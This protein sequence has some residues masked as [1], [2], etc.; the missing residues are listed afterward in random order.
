M[1]FLDLYESDNQQQNADANNGA[2]NNV[3][4]KKEEPKGDVITI[5]T[6]LGDLEKFHDDRNAR[7][8]FLNKINRP[9][10]Q[11]DK[12]FTYGGDGTGKG[13]GGK[14]ISYTTDVGSNQPSDDF[15][16][17][18]TKIKDGHSN[19]KE[20]INDVID[21]VENSNRQQYIK[22]YF[23]PKLE[24]PALKITATGNAKGD[25][26]VP[27]TEHY[28][29]FGQ[30]MVF[31]AGKCVSK[32]T[33][34]DTKIGSDKFKEIMQG[35]FGAAPGDNHEDADFLDQFKDLESK[36][37]IDAAKNVIKSIH[38]AG[39][40]D[41][42]GIETESY[43]SG[44]SYLINN[45]LFEADESDKSKSGVA[46]PKTIDE[47]SNNAG[48]ALKQA[49]AVAEKYPKQYKL[50]YEK[51]RAAFDEGVEDYQKKERDP[52]LKEIENP[53][54][55]EV[56]HRHGKAWGAGGPNAFIRDNPDLK[57]ITDKIRQGTPGCEGVG[58][59]DIFNFGPKLILTM[60]D[61]LEKGG[62][63]YQK[64]C[65]DLGEGMRQIKRSLGA[66]KP[67]DFDKLIK[68]YSDENQHNKAMEI[69]FSAV[70]CA[71]ANVYKILGNGKI[72]QV[73]FNT[74]TFNTEN[75]GSETV[76]QLRLDELKN[77]IAKL[78]KEEA[79]YTKWKE[80]EDKKHAEHIKKLEEEIKQAESNKDKPAEQQNSGGEGKPEE[81]K[82][83]GI[84][85]KKDSYVKK[86]S[87]K[88]LLNEEEKKSKHLIVKK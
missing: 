27:G 28:K 4:A 57:A 23:I 21:K 34:A 25:Y 26:R 1:R 40:K 32:L 37:K 43:Y 48:E 62:K 15:K 13:K 88:D 46:C 42:D 80:E 87:L 72:G 35:C 81:P 68:K 79:D 14:S 8:K 49:K 33:D 56:E 45:K 3:V 2:Q 24:N 74:C 58:G 10:Q 9:G 85:I 5:D 69:S 73:N 11:P 50:W 16:R 41:I 63:I 53:I 77:A 84:S 75:S 65:D 47:F 19:W 29:K 51:L 52:D 38:N 78:T 20:E 86:F 64:L 61:A 31:Y 22:T 82:K 18:M 83:D 39:T 76:I 71:L 36:M 59:W 17:I 54:T 55:G 6:V 30:A 12:A 7:L 60:F 70:I 67:A 44:V 66:T